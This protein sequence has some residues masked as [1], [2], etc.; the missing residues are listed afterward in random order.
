M[1]DEW[2][3]IRGGPIGWGVLMYVLLF[4]GCII[5]TICG[6]LLWRIA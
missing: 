5:G 3:D 2:E 1:I 6:L 4:Y